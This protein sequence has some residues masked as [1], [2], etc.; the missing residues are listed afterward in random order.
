MSIACLITGVSLLWLF[1]NA[2]LVGTGAVGAMVIII[3]PL[4]L[5]MI[6]DIACCVGFSKKTKRNEIKNADTNKVGIVIYGVLCVVTGLLG[7]A[8]A[9]A[10]VIVIGF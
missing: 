5:M 6:V 7:L 4:W 9:V 1:C 8:A 10:P 2:H 3:V